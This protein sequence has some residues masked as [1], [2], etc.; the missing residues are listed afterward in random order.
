[1]EPLNRIVAELIGE[2]LV[3]DGIIKQKD[4]KTL[5]LVDNLLN[6]P[7]EK[8]PK[9]VMDVLAPYLPASRRD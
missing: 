5:T 6:E 9:E 2:E 3:R 4:E 1:M 8:W 7:P